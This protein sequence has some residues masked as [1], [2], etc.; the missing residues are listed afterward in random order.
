M[1]DTLEN[2]IWRTIS[3]FLRGKGIRNNEKAKGLANGSIGLLSDISNASNGS[4]TVCSSRYF[5]CCNRNPIQR[6]STLVDIVFLTCEDARDLNSKL[7]DVKNISGHCLC[8]VQFADSHTFICNYALL[9]Q[10]LRATESLAFVN[11][12][13]A[14]KDPQLGT[15]PPEL[16]SFISDDLEPFLSLRDSSILDDVEDDGGNCLG[17]VDLRV[18]SVYLEKQNS[19][20]S[21][22]LLSFSY[23]KTVISE[24]EEAA[25]VSRMQLVYDSRLKGQHIWNE[26]CA[27]R[28]VDRTLSIVAL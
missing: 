8:V 7:K 27:I 23:P 19:E 4:L 25:L 13:K 20:I 6:T 3:V 2:Y 22:K 28:I 9:G 15:F 11:V 21:H 10:R 12:N 5:S 14:M 1:S 24:I 17:N 16:F 26:S 18:C